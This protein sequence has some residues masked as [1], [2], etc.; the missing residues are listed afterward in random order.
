LNV[1]LVEFIATLR[2]HY[3]I[4]LLSNSFLGVRE[5][6][7]ERYH[8]QEMAD[9]IVYSHEVGLAKPDPRIYEL[10]CNRLGLLPHETLFLD[11]YEPNVIAAREFGL[12][13]ILFEDTGEA[14]AQVCA[15]L[16]DSP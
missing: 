12:Q 13:A 10:A 7:Q 11:D 14:I 1:Q 4:A 3:K 6:E 5:R 16:Q 9:L 15:L 8:F 2:P